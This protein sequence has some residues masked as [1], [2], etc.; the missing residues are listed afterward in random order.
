MAFALLAFCWT[1]APLVACALPEQMMTP[2]ERDC[3]E[4]MPHM[5]DSGTMPQ[6]HSCCHKQVRSNNTIVIKNDQ[7]SAPASASIAVV[8]AT[9]PGVVPEEVHK[10]NHHH[11]LTLFLPDTAVLRI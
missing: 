10:A 7:Q 9:T 11:P 2:A 4:H 1:A 5:C 8:G 3:C 6:S